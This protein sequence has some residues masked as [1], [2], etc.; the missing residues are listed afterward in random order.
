M[1]NQT[2][3]AG[4]KTFK[5]VTHVLFDMDGL[6][7]DTERL[8]TVSFQEICERFGK[9]Y[10]WE[11]KAT[12]MGQKALVASQMIRD[13][14]ELPM[15]AEELLDESREDLSL[16]TAD[17]SSA[18]STYELKT[19][20][21]REFFGLFHHVVLGDDPQVAHGKPRPDAFLV[22]AGRFQPPAAPDQ[23]GML[24]NARGL[25]EVQL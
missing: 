22:A 23:V 1:D 6:L 25:V 4:S 11:V 19:S 9:R 12:V 24:R 20:R 18:G 8:Y 13:A 3:D 5:A 17:A 2:P 10:T 21:H 14:L 16:G 15:S 7:L